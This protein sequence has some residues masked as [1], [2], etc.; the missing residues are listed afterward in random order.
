MTAKYVEFWWKHA[1]FRCFGFEPT[2]D[3]ILAAWFYADE[4]IRTGG[5]MNEPEIE[6]L[7]DGVYLFLPREGRAQ[8]Y[9]RPG[10]LCGRGSYGLIAEGELDAMRQVAKLYHRGE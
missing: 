6:R 4:A 1:I 9:Q 5:K 7:G 10:H 3:A 2:R 8:I